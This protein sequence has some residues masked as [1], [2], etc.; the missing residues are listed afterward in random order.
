MLLHPRL[1]LLLIVLF[2]TMALKSVADSP[3]D[4]ADSLYKEALEFTRSGRNLAARLKLRGAVSLWK[5]SGQTGRA[6]TALTETAAL[7]ESQGWFQ[8]ALENYMNVLSDPRLARQQ[9]AD[10]SA[11]LARLYFRLHQ[12][13]LALM[14][15][16]QT[17]YMGLQLGSSSIQAVSLAGIAAV[18]AK[19]GNFKESAAYSSRATMKASASGSERE[20]AEAFWLVGRA[21]E[22]RELIAEAKAAFQQALSHYQNALT[23][24][25]EHAL[26]LTDL[27]SL[28]L[29]SG[30]KEAAIAY[31]EKARKMAEELKSPELQWRSW[32]AVGN[33]QRASGQIR[34]A[35]KSFYRAFSFI[36]MEAMHLSSES[37]R[38][39]FIQERFLPYRQLVNTLVDLGRY[40]E[41]LR[42]VE[43]S[44][45]R[46][47]LDTL[48]ASR[49]NSAN[50]DQL[51]E[52][53]ELNHTIASL[54][55]A[56]NSLLTNN[57]RRSSLE[58]A[59][60]DVELRKKEIVIQSESERIKQFTAP[61]TLKQ[62]QEETL[63]RN[64]VLLEFFLGDDRS[65]VWLVSANEVKCETLPGRKTIEMNVADYLAL[66]RKKP[67]NIH[68][69][70]ELNRHRAAGGKVFDMLFGNLKEIIKSEDHL[71]I[72]PD[73]FLY[74]LPFE[75]LMCGDRF[76]IE[77][78]AVTYC[79]SAS[80]LSLLR[81]SRPDSPA[82]GQM[83]MLAV[84]DPLLE[85]FNRQRSRFEGNADSKQIARPQ[86]ELNRLL[87]A[88]DEVEY[89]GA[90]FPPGRAQVYLGAKATETTF[91]SEAGKGYRRLH[92]ATHTLVDE[93]SPTRSGILFARDKTSE[94]DGFLGLE[95]IGR[96]NLK[97]CELIVLSSCQTGR[98][99]LVRGEGL[100]GLGR[101]FMLAGAR[102][103]TMSLWNV[104][105]FST[106]TIM[107]RFYR[108]IG[109]GKDA[110]ESLRQAKLQMIQARPTIHP[111]YW[112]AF[113]V[114]GNP[115]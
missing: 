69:E 5:E 37:L 28:S 80:I 38:I 48:S 109:D 15:Y 84:G 111:F 30:E 22:T 77:Q 97:G 72:I 52:L 106:A 26:L 2:F 82:I 10:I 25:E 92:V 63:Q 61:A 17:L 108:S 16:R 65:Y 43:Y 66:I 100:I 27:S 103:V 9:K 39:S 68:L 32:L 98:G 51:Q 23:L 59:L 86:F 112:A 67:S 113:I 20:K 50:L 42:I 114:M 96:L 36:E 76:L 45:A 110:G 88:R 93:L 54:N 64:E 44:R 4:R 79:P 78:H 99:Q 90:V 6:V 3:R 58:S 1:A 40:S 107:K 8:D 34:E 87:G 95:E 19:H 24:Y 33:T 57:E 47:A 41:A 56:L 74:Y 71:I 101:A 29:S 115:T 21:Y 53:K 70:K 35:L 55:A 46:T 18:S 12:L 73:G 81:R 83:D 89:I 14:Y 11:S 85:G 94:D 7:F 13:D 31:A 62:I 102:S 91:K 49:S 104:S 105:D 60:E 75:S